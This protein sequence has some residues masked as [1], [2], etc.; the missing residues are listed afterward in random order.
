MK[1]ASPLRKSL[2]LV[3]CAIA[4]A[5]FAQQTN[6]LI[7]EWRGVMRDASNYNMAFDITYYPNNT[8]V[9]TM[10]VPPNR[11]TGTGS[12]IIYSR[13]QYRMTSDHT[14]ELNGQERKACPAGDMSSCVPMPAAG[15]QT[16]SFRMEGADKVINTDNGQVAYRVR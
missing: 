10:A 6:P 15:V 4:G 1:M 12:G 7:G 5:A 3:C 8:F 2:F 9:Q 11:E 16:I 14:V 13:G